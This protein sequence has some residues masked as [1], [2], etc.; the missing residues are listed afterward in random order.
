MA[1]PDFQS[2][3]LPF[4][5]IAADKQTH[6]YK[7]VVTGL[8]AWFKLTG[9]E[10]KELLPSGKQPVFENRAGWA[11]THLKKAGLLRYPQRGYIQI[12]ERGLSILEQKPEKIDMKLLKQFDEYNEFTKITNLDKNDGGMA[13]GTEIHTPEE[14]MESAFQ[15]IKRTLADEILEKVRSIAPSFFEKLVVDLLVKMGYGGSIKDAGKA[16]GKASDEGIDG[17][18]KEDKLG[19][20]VIYIQAKRWKDGNV[21]GRPELHK[22]VGALAGQGAKKGIF[23]TASSFSKE[24]LEYTPKNETKIILIDGIQLSELMIEYNIGVSNQ[25]TYEIKKIDNDY[26]DEE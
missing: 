1:M 18:I 26:F 12:T 11:K 24:A 21:V 16:V 23:I 13:G 20:D 5:N 6:V 7:D 8:A 25:Q 10:E 14:L 3:M 4:M 17:T 22:F 19:L 9:E 15:N 2:I